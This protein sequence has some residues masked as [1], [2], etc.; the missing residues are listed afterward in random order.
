MIDKNPIQWEGE[1][2]MSHFAYHYRG[3]DA[4]LF[5]IMLYPGEGE[6]GVIIPVSYRE[7][8]P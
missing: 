4:R 3:F 1:M 8:P 5:L 2:L 6:I 7:V